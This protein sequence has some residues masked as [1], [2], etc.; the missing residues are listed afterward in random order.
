M[1]DR[2]RV[3]DGWSLAAD[4]RDEVAR[5]A[6]EWGRDGKLGRL[7]ARDAALWTGADESLWLG[8]LDAPGDPG[9]A[10][11]L[12]HARA[13]REGMAE[14]RVEQIVLLGMGGSSLCPEVLARTFDRRAFHV[15]D[16]TDPGQIARLESRIDLR[17]TLFI[18][19][20]KSGTTLESDVL[21]RYFFDR[22]GREVPS[23]AGRRFVAITDP[24]SQLESIARS[25]GYRA[26]FHGVP[27]I[28]GRYS[29]LSPFGLVPAVLMG[30]DAARLLESAASVAST[31]AQ[32]DAHDGNETVLL[33][34]VMG[35]AALAGRDKVTLIASPLVGALGAWIEQLL[36]ESTGKEGKG[37]IPI[38]GETP[39]SP[40]RYAPDRLFVH[41][42]SSPAAGEDA[43]LARQVDALRAAG[44]PIVTI[45]IDDPHSLGGEFFRWEMASAVAGSL[46]GIHPFDQ[47]DVEAA[48]VASRQLTAAFVSAGALPAETPFVSEG[49]LRIFA[50]EGLEP[51]EPGGKTGLVD[52]LSAHFGRMTKGDYCAL[53]AWVARED[54]YE[55]PLQEIRHVIRAAKRAA[56]T[57][58]FGPRY[59]HS[60]GQEHKGG[61]ASGLFLQVIGQ[62]ENDLQAPGSPCSFGILKT[63]QARGDFDVLVARGRRVL[64]VDLG[65]D[66]SRGLALLA[67][68]VKRALA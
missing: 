26:L 48:K 7:L 51:V 13:L 31:S 21:R 25:D 18:V 24:G 38:D 12:A 49:E 34:I 45:A 59:L 54:R 57:L 5:T 50:D 3:P 28:G 46:L 53:L 58:G 47:P 62:D 35:V 11:V 4:L 65:R 23:G 64:R 16:S 27:A 20:S 56:T 1:P 2:F 52:L 67:E 30:V 10:S 14:E 61:P 55:A 60:T 19:S 39:S 41:L 43:A 32:V 37:I 33:G 66:V 36:A 42:R 8:W 29:A 6:G 17:S 44:H 63:A 22:V 15:L 40:D 9:A 68:A